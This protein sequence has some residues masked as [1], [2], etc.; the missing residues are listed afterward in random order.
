[1]AEFIEC[2]DGGLYVR[3]MNDRPTLKQELDAIRER[4]PAWKARYDGLVRRLVKAGIGS[5][6]LK[7]GDRCPDFMLSNAEGE[8]VDSAGLLSRGPLVLSFYRG[9]WC[10]Y[11]VTELEALREVAPQ[12]RNEGATLAAVT[13][14]NCGGA[15]LAKRERRL[16]FEIL[17]DFENGLSLNFGL[18]FRVPDDIRDAYLSIGIDF[19]L[20]YGNH[21]WFLPIPATYV[22]APDGVIRHAYINPDFRER[23]DPAQILGV[24]HSLR[25]E[26]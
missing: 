10:P 16:E 11:C 8:L 3:R 20:M 17:C 21:S 6:A 25:R 19:P 23:M 22:I 12:I 4:D 9:R 14:E 1:M 26:A 2:E 24:L 15:L 13:A 5:A 18:V 7:A